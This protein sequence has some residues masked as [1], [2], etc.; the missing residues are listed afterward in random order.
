VGRVAQ[1]RLP[2][3]IGPRTGCRG[4]PWHNP[5]MDSEKVKRLIVSGEVASSGGGLHH[6][7]ARTLPVSG[8]WGHPVLVAVSGGA[9]SV[10]LLCVLCE[11]ARR[12]GD[13]TAGRLVVAH[14]EHD[15]RPTARRDRDFVQGI[16]A[17]L[18]LPF[19]CRRLSVLT[20]G[21]R[22]EG[23]EATARRLRYDFL[24][25][26]AEDRGCRHV[27]V[28][29]TADD[30]AE[31][32]LHR[33]LRGTGLAGLGGMP[34]ARALRDGISLVRPLLGV[35]RAEVRSFLATVGGAW[36]EDETNADVAR[37][38]NFLRHEILPRLA[39]GPYPAASA[40]LVTLGRQ[41][42]AVAGAVASAA[43]HL[44]DLH[45]SR[46]ADGST[47]L[48]TR[49]LQSLDRHLVAEVFVALW[50]R[51]G[52][53]RRHL[54]ARHYAVLADMVRG[55]PPPAVDLPGGIHARLLAGGL[56]EVRISGGRGRGPGNRP[57]VGRSR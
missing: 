44:L 56:L 30:Q 24:A 32:I 42:A 29:H 38:R 36:Q 31:T 45:G 48:R 40:S 3:E 14:A 28:A 13:A 20:E 19:I 43:G 25:A 5:D 17:S 11:I 27:A 23:V 7:V 37:A 35:T 22:G 55:E 57:A 46:Q 34:R 18:G 10:A 1:C 50:R 54:T 12:H 2:A 39:A 52:W 41:A 9:D 21:G 6:V 33:S 16:A 4:G 8:F 47:I 53:P 51:E 15:L 26:A 49:P